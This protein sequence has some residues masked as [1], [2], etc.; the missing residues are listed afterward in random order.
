M[1]VDRAEPLY[2]LVQGRHNYVDDVDYVEL[3][4]ITLV[5]RYVHGLADKDIL[6]YTVLTSTDI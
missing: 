2:A 3:S 4:G 5:N 1:Q 6:Q